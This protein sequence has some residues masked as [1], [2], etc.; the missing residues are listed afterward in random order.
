MMTMSDHD[1]LREYVRSQSEAAFAELVRRY[2]GLVH[3]AAQRQVQ[4]RQLAE[5][6]TQ[7]VFVVLVRKA[8]RL[9][10]DVVLAGWLLK[11]ARYA[12][13]A[14]MRADIRRKQREQE[15]SMQS[16]LNES[17]VA[18]EQLAPHLDVAMSKLGDAD[19]NAIALRYFENKTAPEIAAALKVNEEAAQKRVARALEKLRK[20]FSKRG[21]TLT[22]VAIAGALSANSVQAAP[23][24][25]A[26]SISGTAVHGTLVSAA[27][28][29]LVKGTMKLMTWTKIKLA[30]AVGT[31]VSLV[32]GTATLA[33]YFADPE[34][35]NYLEAPQTLLIQPSQYRDT[36]FSTGGRGDGDKTVGRNMPL[37]IMM[38]HAYG[39]SQSRMIFSNTPPTETYD[40]LVTVTNRPHQSFQ[41][42]IKSQLGWAG[43][44]EIREADALL[45]RAKNPAILES[46]VSPKVSP[47]NRLRNSD[48]TKFLDWPN[49]R[50]STLAN[51]LEGFFEKPVIDKTGLTN[52]YDI[53]L[54]GK[55]QSDRQ[56]N[57]DFISK[58]LGDQLGLE[59]VPS[60]EK[61]E[62]LVVEKVK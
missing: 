50:I 3:S 61:V 60:R 57:L 29:T 46:K 33:I 34:L 49:Q 11:T 28:I 41:A 37:Q 26:I 21:V 24:G 15:A 51:M 40:W 35:K 19:R 16:M 8:Q 23:V 30:M 48:R 62:M 5:E 39:F 4:D 32:A 7:A 44:V 58:A 45:L 47:R 17:T 20:I 12:A 14:Q 52:F 13:Q 27:I 53:T 10:P 42:L 54:E 25:L 43:R 1:L 38:A 6:I 31:V 18:W 56:A 59:L 9:G 36:H 2:V 55:W 22:A